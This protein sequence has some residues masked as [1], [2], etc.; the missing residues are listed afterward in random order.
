MKDWEGKDLYIGDEVIH[1]YVLGSS[2]EFTRAYVVS[3]TE[4]RVRL[5]QSR[6]GKGTV[7]KPS[8]CIRITQHGDA[9]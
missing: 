7:C 1:A 9:T 4:K 5:S 6:T 8:K 3:F 2:V